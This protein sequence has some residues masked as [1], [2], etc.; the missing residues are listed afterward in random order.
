MRDSTGAAIADLRSLTFELSPPVLY[1]LGLEPALQYLAE[2]ME[3]EHGVPVQ[4]RDDGLEKPLRDDLRVTLYR[5]VRE[6]LVN[7]VKHARASQ[8]KVSVSR[9]GDRI[10]ILV[11]DDGVGFDSGILEVR[12]PAGGG[13]GL[14]S[15]RERLS[16]VEGRMEIDSRAGSGARITL[17]VPLAV[18]DTA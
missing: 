5:S 18:E 13:F 2:Q 10:R 3:R 17:T 7:A 16:C 1:E 4:Y 6:L 14:F 11:E 8:L 15:I 9:L 12:S